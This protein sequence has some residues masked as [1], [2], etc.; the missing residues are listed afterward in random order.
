MTWKEIGLLILLAV[1]IVYIILLIHELRE[2][3]ED[4]KGM[5]DNGWKDGSGRGYRE[6]WRDGYSIG[7]KETLTEDDLK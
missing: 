3:E 5:Y 1:C 7:R 6:G 2:A 4:K